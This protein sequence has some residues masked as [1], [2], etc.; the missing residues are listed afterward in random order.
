M[1]CGVAWPGTCSCECGRAPDPGGGRG[2]GGGGLT[3]GAPGLRGSGAWRRPGARGFSAVAAR[4]RAPGAP[5]ERRARPEPGAGSR[6]PGRSEAAPGA[7]GL[8]VR[9][10][11]RGRA[12]C[13]GPAVTEEGWAQGASL[14][15]PG[16]PADQP[17][18]VPGLWNPKGPVSW[19]SRGPL[20][21]LMGQ[22]PPPRPS[23]PLCKPSAPGARPG[24]M[25][26]PGIHAASGKTSALEG[27]DG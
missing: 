23:L 21:M 17:V 11:R 1:M 4:E 8:C 25:V 18:V 20:G 16:P 3:A 19:S 9:W 5:R 7:G 14:G 12:A 10:G 15:C 26:D 22:E 24:R 27:P 6:A 13:L 2:A